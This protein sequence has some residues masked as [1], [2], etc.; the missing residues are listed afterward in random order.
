MPLGP[1]RVEGPV[2][3]ASLAPTSSVF[4]GN[5]GL[6]DQRTAQGVRLRGVDV[7]VGELA[8]QGRGVAAEVDDAVVF[9][10]SLQFARVFFRVI[11]HQNPLDGADHLSA[12]LETLL[13]QAMRSE[14]H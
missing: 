1:S 6:L 7:Y 10:P 4:T 14:E 9:G 8:D 11:G 13:V 12:D 5:R 2:S 3:R